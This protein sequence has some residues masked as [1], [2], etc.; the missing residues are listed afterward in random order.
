M[1][2]QER[3][4]AILSPATDDVVRRRDAKQSRE[5]G[6]IV[7]QVAVE[8]GNDGAGGRLNTCPQRSALAS[9]F[10]MLEST[11]TN[12]S[13]RSCSCAVMTMSTQPSQKLKT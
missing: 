4:L 12:I 11:D 1:A 10:L 7:L 3:V 6:G 9:V 8:S 13:A 5:I 2:G